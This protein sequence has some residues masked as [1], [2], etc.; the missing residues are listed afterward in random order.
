MNNTI[1][2]LNQAKL[3]Q[4]LDGL[5]HNAPQGDARD[6]SLAGDAS[7]NQLFGNDGHDTIRGRSGNDF[8]VGGNEHEREDMRHEFDDG[9]EWLTWV[10]GDEPQSGNDRIYGE[11]GND[12]LVGGVGHDLLDGGPGDDYLIGDNLVITIST[13]AP[14]YTPASHVEGD[15]HDVLIGG[16]GEDYLHGGGGA[17]ILNGGEGDDTLVAGGY[18]DVMIGG[19]GNDVFDFESVGS[20]DAKIMDFE[21]GT[22]K[23][24][25]EASSQWGYFNPHIH[26]QRLVEYANLEWDW[27]WMASE[28]EDGV[29]IN[30]SDGVNAE[31]VGLDMD[32]LTGMEL[33]SYPGYDGSYFIA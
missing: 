31:L 26:L 4:L 14:L 13:G 21:I 7:I 15:G 29:V 6:N 3:E 30:L 1:A 17:N 9:V 10:Y 23:I 25:L 5:R 32:D 27:S 22:D 19:E 12:V 16:D 11:D 28:T 33:V 24:R 8:L 18:R 20:N 2:P